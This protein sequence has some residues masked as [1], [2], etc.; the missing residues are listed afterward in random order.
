VYL[1]KM[2]Q[3][4]VMIVTQAQERNVQIVDILITAKPVDN[5]A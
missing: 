1:G 5:Y 2:L 3:T 4:G